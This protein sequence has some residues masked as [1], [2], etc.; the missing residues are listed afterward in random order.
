MRGQALWSSECWCVGR[1][2]Y[3][4]LPICDWLACR[5]PLR[6]CPVCEREAALPNGG[7]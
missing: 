5:V 7:G 3:D 4:C 1:W 2:C 6:S